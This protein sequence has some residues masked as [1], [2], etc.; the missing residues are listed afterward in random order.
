VEQAPLA[1]EAVRRLRVVAQQLKALGV[2]VVELHHPVAL[3]AHWE[4]AL[5]LSALHAPALGRSV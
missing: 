1:L 3:V 5:G 4:P 2:W